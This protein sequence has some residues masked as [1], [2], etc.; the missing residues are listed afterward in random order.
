[1]SLTAT[2][3]DTKFKRLI[4]GYESYILRI[5]Y[6]FKNINSLVDYLP[7]NLVAMDKLE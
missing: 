7:E 1:M 5:D 4:K 6:M 3:Y 2:A